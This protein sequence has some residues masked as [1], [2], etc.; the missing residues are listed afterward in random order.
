MQALVDALLRAAHDA[1]QMRLATLRLQA[2]LA[3]WEGNVRAARE[4]CGEATME[5][6]WFGDPPSVTMP[7][8][9]LIAIE[10][11]LSGDHPAAQR[12]L[13]DIA[14]F[15]GRISERR[16][17]LVFMNLLGG[18][19]TAS[20]DWLSAHDALVTIEAT[21]TL[22][23]PF[24]GLQTTTLRA[25]LALH[26]GNPAQAL[27]LLRPLVD[28]A[29]DADHY[30]VN[31]R[32]RVALA[33]A[34]QRAGS[35]QAAW[36]VLRPALHQAMDAGEPLG[37]LLCGPKALDE[38]AQA[39]WP[40]AADPLALAY[41]RNCAAR[42]WQLRTSGTESVPAWPSDNPLSERELE[43]LQL[44]ARGQSNKLIARVLGLSPHTVKRHMARILDKTGQASRGQV[45]AWYASRSGRIV[46]SKP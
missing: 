6:K 33:R 8:Q 32:L 44:V 15:A 26:R 5:A 38:L 25:E 27:S 21:D 4:L 39:H 28:R 24:I 20:E 17:G 41:L 22:E 29:M 34:E 36:K 43:V 23:W 31:A 1:P 13:R 14:D 10:R 18:F 40:E 11:H 19:A 9:L 37:L 12:I 42:A 7:N 46:T 30:G 16:S 35:A 45:A 2:W 3:L